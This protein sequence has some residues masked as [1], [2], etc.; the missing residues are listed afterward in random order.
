MRRYFLFHF[1][2]LMIVNNV[3]A[4]NDRE[5]SSDNPFRYPASTQQVITVESGSKGGFHGL[6]VCY[7]K[8][9]EGWKKIYTFHV[10]TGEAGIIEP[11]K[12][13][14]GDKAT[15]AGVYKLGF[16]FGYGQRPDTRMEYRELSDDDKW[17]DDPEHPLYNRLVTGKT[18][19]RSFEKMRREDN[20]YRLGIV[21]NYNTDP[22]VKYKGSAIFLHIWRDRDAGTS[23]C[24]ALSEEDL[25][26]IIS[27]LDPDKNP[28]IIIAEPSS[29]VDTMRQE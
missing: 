26:A 11:K 19:A 20:L 15:P 23:G 17:I 29:I 7:E 1:F 18:D 12:K 16:A 28:L 21:I 10:V 9:E 13:N 4:M 27:W 14:E 6:V 22:V 5:C 8:A 2:L 25:K 24:V 3:Q